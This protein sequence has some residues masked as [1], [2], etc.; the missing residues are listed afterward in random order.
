[1]EIE[2]LYQIFLKNPVV[3]TDSRNVPAGS[4]YFALQGEHFDGNTFAS[5][6]LLKGASFAIID[7]KDFQADNRYFFV[8]NVLET[9]QRLANHHRR[10]INTPIIAITGTNGKTTTKELINN[11]LSRKY[12]VHSTLGNLNNNIGVPL[13]LLSMDSHTEIGVVEMGAN[14]VHEID[15]L[16]TIAEPDFGIITNV[17]KAHLEGF[18][19]YQGVIKAK[20]ELYQYLM[21]NEHLIFYNSDS[22]LLSDLI[23][24]YSKKIS[25]GL[26][27]GTNCR[28]KII[29]NDPYLNVEVQKI[30]DGKNVERV[31]IRS[32]FFGDYNAENIL[33]A[34]S[35]GIYFNLT[36]EDLNEA[37]TSYIPTNNR[38]QIKET[39]LNKLILDCY[40]ANPSSCEMAIRNFLS[41]QG[42]HK[43]MILG[44]MYELGNESITEH[45]KILDLV[46]SQKDSKVLLVGSCYK[47]LAKDYEIMAFENSDELKS[48]IT[49]HPISNHFVLIKGSRGNK[50]EKIIDVL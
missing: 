17:G 36:L 13:T 28:G 25:Y 45:K 15:Q 31:T 21:K 40:N 8:D 34:C 4:I 9:L 38:S 22:P 5:E 1:M 50:L 16:C 44:D 6:A 20:N 11:V 46:S 48:W 3:T 39:N 2:H 32:H 18:G 35:T 49:R 12:I 26:K 33:A 19:G 29:S 43:M 10:K 7:N 42:D 14:H 30:N 24:N 27:S 37:I 47:A 23:L 41:A